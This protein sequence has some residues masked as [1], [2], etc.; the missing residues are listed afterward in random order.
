MNTNFMSKPLPEKTVRYNGFVI[1][2]REKVKNRETHGGIVRVGRS[3]V[4]PECITLSESSESTILFF[5]LN[6]TPEIHFCGQ[7]NPFDSFLLIDLFLCS[8]FCSL[9]DVSDLAVRA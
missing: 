3:E 1:R 5:L 7:F 8:S 4:I 2:S 9:T 6:K